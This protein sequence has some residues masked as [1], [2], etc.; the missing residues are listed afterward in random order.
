MKF[1]CKAYLKTTH[2]F[3]HSTK[4]KVI[5]SLFRKNKSEKI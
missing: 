2:F 5:K 4:A 3:D 1:I